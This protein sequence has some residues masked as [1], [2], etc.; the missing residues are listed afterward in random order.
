MSKTYICIPRMEIDVSLDYIRKTI[1]KLG[2]GVIRRVV[3]IPLHNDHNY[4]RI[5]IYVSWS[6]KNNYI[7]N[8]LQDGKSIK[9]VH[10][11]PWYWRLIRGTEGLLYRP[12]TPP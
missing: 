10:N 3:E 5:M 6:N 12:K 1:D 11:G 9:L 8:M 2:I 4:K 7:L